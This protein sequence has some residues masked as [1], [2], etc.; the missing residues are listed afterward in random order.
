VPKRIPVRCGRTLAYMHWATCV[1]L[2]KNWIWVAIPG[3]SN[4]KCWTCPISNICSFPIFSHSYH[5][6]WSFAISLRPNLQTSCGWIK[7]SYSP[8]RMM[9]WK[10]PAGNPSFTHGEIPWPEAVAPRPLSRRW[11]P[12]SEPKAS[13]AALITSV[14]LGKH[15]DLWICIYIYNYII[16]Y[17]YKSYKLM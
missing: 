16:L 4:W 7:K 14:K 17:I 12:R 8:R 3:M 10:K 9:S 6:C 2:V 5:D 11:R 13:M 1:Q 15:R